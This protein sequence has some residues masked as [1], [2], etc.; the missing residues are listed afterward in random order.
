MQV[1][2][3]RNKGKTYVRIEFGAFALTLEIPV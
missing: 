3:H 2:I 1:T